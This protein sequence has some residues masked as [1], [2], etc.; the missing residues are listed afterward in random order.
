MKY[1][2]YIIEDD[3]GLANGIKQLANS[4][5]FD[6]YL[7]NDFHNIIN[8]F[9]EY[10]PHIILLD[11]KLPFMNGYYWCT[12]IRKLSNV[13]ILFISSASDNMSAI[14]AMNMGGDDFVAKP[15]DSNI[16]IAKLQAVLRRTYDFNDQNRFLYCADVVLN[17]N[18]NTLM[19]NNQKIDLT[20]NE[21]RILFCLLEN[22]GKVVSREKLMQKLWETD[23]YID[24]NTLTVNV[25]RLRKKLADYGLDKFINTKFGVGYIVEE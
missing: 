21:Y 19:Y 8:E 5:D 9:N 4:Y 20:K 24:E 2:L 18:D 15:F 6:T 1:K 14:M 16:L 25:N 12:E 3:D 11:I 7:C 13:P 10:K 23:C 22:K 17:T